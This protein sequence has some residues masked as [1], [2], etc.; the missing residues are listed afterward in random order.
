MVDL[1]PE[2]EGLPV[3]DGVAL[4]AHVLPHPV[5]LHLRVAL[6]AQRPA[7]RSI[8]QLRVT[9]TIGPSQVTATIG[10]LDQNDYKEHHRVVATIN[11]PGSRLQ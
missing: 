8:H 6:V 3:N 9:A 10:A 1:S 5:R 11:P 4:L 2:P 7:L